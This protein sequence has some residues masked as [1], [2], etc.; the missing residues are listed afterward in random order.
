VDPAERRS[1]EGLYGPR[2]EAWRLNREA[3]LLLG[4]GPRALLLQVAHPLIAEGVDQHSDFRADP[5]RRLQGTLRSY[6]RIVY[7][8]TPQARDEI[9]RLNVLHRSIAGPVRDAAARDLGASSYSARDP[10]LGLWVHAT[11]VDSTLVA[12][13]A[14]LEPLSGDRRARFYDETRP[15]A[16]AFG[17]PDALLP[18][19]IEG[20]ERYL[21]DMLSPAGPVH[22]TSTARALAEV[23][24]HPPLAPIHPLLGLLPARS[25]DWTF[26]P[27]IALLPPGVREEF[28]IAW[29]PTRRAVARWLLLGM[30]LWRPLMPPSLRWMP[31]ALAADRRIAPN[32]AR[33]GIDQRASSATPTLRA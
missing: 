31:Q 33:A 25:Y 10:G 7:G 9:R 21:A 11:L 22:V 16:R 30:E 24:L 1:I 17:I 8:S 23:V 14:W 5:W 4:A 13:D 6:L 18:P 26:W 2:S 12:A 32:V 19:D 27:S 15:I 3:M 20:F 29:T 28:G